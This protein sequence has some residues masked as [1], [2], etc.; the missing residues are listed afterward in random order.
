MMEYVEIRLESGF[1]LV[2]TGLRILRIM[3]EYDTIMTQHDAT[4][5]ISILLLEC[6]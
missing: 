3:I 1:V 5:F 6:I 4:G 2:Q